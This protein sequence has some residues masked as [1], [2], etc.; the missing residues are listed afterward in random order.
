MK[1]HGGLHSRILEELDTIEHR[2]GDVWSIAVPRVEGAR[3]F[4]KLKTRKLDL[5]AGVYVPDKKLLIAFG[6]GSAKGRSKIVLWHDSEKPQ[7][8][9]VDHEL[10]EVKDAGTL[11][12][13]FREEKRFSGSELNIEGAVLMTD[14]KKRRVVRL[15]Q[16]GNGADSEIPAISASCD[17]V[18]DELLQYLQNPITNPVPKIRKIRQYDLGKLLGVKLSFT[19]ASHKEQEPDRSE[20]LVFLAG[21]EDSPDSFHDGAVM[22]S[23]FG[24]IRCDALTKR[25]SGVHVPLTLPD[26]K[27]F[28]EKAEGVVFERNDPSR[29]MIVIDPDDPLIACRICS[30]QLYGFTSTSSPQ[31]ASEPEVPHVA[32][33]LIS[34]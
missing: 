31:P 23:T 13:A 24:Q 6:S 32:S 29:V 20:N 17:I 18:L 1:H 12:R 27:L 28:R 26:G 21:A 15:F 30:V 33:R 4:H 2:I 14:R 34:H 22:G 16:R 5:E 9:F 10:L 19:D 8:H 7:A 25:C 11:Y 3:Q